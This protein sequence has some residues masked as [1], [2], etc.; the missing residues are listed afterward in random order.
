LRSGPH[1]VLQLGSPTGLYGAE[2]WI[3]ALVRELDPARVESHVGVIRDD[4]ALEAPLCAAAAALGLRTHIFE[5][6]GRFNPRAI[7]QMRQYIGDH[8]IDILHTHGYKGD[9]LG[10]PAVRGTGCRLLSTP[11]GWSTDAGFMLQVY[12]ALDRI[13]LMFC[14]AVAPLSPELTDELRRWPGL[15]RR[16][17][18]IRNGV[19]LAE[20]EAGG[21]VAPELQDWRAAGR[22]VVGY[23]GQLIHRKGIATLLH[24]VARLGD[25]PVGIALVG[26][27]PQ[28]AELEALAAQ[29]GLG[30]DRLRF[31]GFRSNRLDFLRG[32]DLFALPSHLEG[33]PRCLMESMGAGIPIVAT[34]IPGCRDLI[35][36]GH[37]GLLFRPG[38]DAGLAAAIRTYRDPVERGRHAANARAKVVAEFSAAAMARAY[39]Q[40]FDRLA[41]RAR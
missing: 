21:A 32:F 19:D 36:P 29:L 14:D 3:L 6:P 17:H 18:Y 35:E 26:E 2:R 30:P 15:G 39:E 20:I 16:L 4:T 28:R 27:G 9:I 1:R 37:T 5:A 7:G 22:L 8:R 33:I 31:F 24:A 40:L 25:E 11:H 38:D 23:I 41:G 13:A 10:L 34:D 12:E